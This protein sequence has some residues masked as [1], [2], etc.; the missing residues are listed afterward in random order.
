VVTYQGVLTVDNSAMLLR[1]GLTANVNIL[2]SE[3]KD[4][5]LLPNGALRF[6]PAGKETTAPLVQPGNGELAGR[7]WVLSGD[8]AVAHDLKIGRTDGRNTEVLSGDLQPGERVITDVGNRAN[9]TA[10]GPQ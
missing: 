7:V 2:V 8:A 10:G 3:T 4:A 9:G 5:L 1:P 6:T